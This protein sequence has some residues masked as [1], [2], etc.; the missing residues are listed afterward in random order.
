MEKLEASVRGVSRTLR[1]YDKDTVPVKV[2][3]VVWDGG[4]TASYLSPAIA[5]F[6]LVIAAAAA[7]APV[8]VVPSPSLLLFISVDKSGLVSKRKSVPRR[9]HKLRLDRGSL[10]RPCTAVR[11]QPNSC[12]A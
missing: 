2:E 11:S 1:W 5:P 10:L 7:A 3:V 12:C 6:P 4:G 8:L 9:H